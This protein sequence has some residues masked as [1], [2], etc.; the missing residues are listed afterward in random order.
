MTGVR[1]RVDSEQNQRLY[2]WLHIGRILMGLVVLLAFFYLVGAIELNR[3]AAAGMKALK[4]DQFA[5]AYQYVTGS[6]PRAT[7]RPEI[8]T[9]QLLYWPQ[10]LLVAMGATLI[11]AAYLV[12]QS[13]QKRETKLGFGLTVLLALMMMVG[14]WLAIGEL[15][16]TIGMAGNDARDTYDA[17][18]RTA[19]Y[20]LGTVPAQLA[21]GLF[22]AYLLFSEVGWGKSLYRTIYFAL[23]RP[24]RRHVHHIP[25]HLRLNDHS[26]ANRCWVCWGLSRS[27]G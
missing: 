6:P 5:R 13:A 9:A 11:G 23:H 25:R 1:R 12:W 14:G 24:Q 4:P 16:H 7:L 2:R 3:Q 10:V 15:P 20:A 19:I 21:L 27:T 18:V 22:L 17:T 26:L 8:V